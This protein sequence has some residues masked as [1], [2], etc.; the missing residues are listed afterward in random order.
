MG[1]INGLDSVSREWD[2]AVSR[3]SQELMMSTR[4]EIA[5]QALALPANDRAFLADVLEQS[6]TDEEL[7][8]ETAIAWSKEIDR[9]LEAYD[10]GELEAVD[11]QIAMEE[12]RRGLAKRR[13]EGAK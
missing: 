7:T 11:A 8:A 1:C 9:R 3:V 6:L 5:Q 13:A 10:R 12:M 2:N 4:D